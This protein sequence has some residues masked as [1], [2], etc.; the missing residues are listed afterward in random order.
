MLTNEK[1]K[2]DNEIKQLKTDNQILQEKMKETPPPPPP[3]TP[4]PPRN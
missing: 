3:P 1:S 4:P 2:L